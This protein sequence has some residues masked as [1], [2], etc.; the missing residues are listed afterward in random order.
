MDIQFR[1][2]TEEY[3]DSCIKAMEHSSMCTAYFQSEES[4]ANA[5]MEGIHRGLCMWFCAAVNAPEIGW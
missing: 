5:V 3:L 2:G 4:R 1:K